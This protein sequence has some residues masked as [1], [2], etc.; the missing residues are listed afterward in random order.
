MIEN[1]N[2]IIFLGA[3]VFILIPFMLNSTI[4][5]KALGTINGLLIIA[6]GFIDNT[7]VTMIQCIFL[8]C[9]LI[10]LRIIGKDLPD[11]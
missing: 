3:L 7:Y 1:I 4:K 9:G 6:L 5:L 10:I 2:I 11:S 8:V